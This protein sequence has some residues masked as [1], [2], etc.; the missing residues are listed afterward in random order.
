MENVEREIVISKLNHLKYNPHLL[1]DNNRSSIINM[2]GREQ[3]M[4]QA[5]VPPASTSTLTETKKSESKHRLSASS[6]A[7]DKSRK[8]TKKDDRPQFGAAMTVQ[9]RRHMVMLWKLGKLKDIPVF[10]QQQLSRQ[11]EISKSKSQAHKRKEEEEHT[12]NL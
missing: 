3:S 5:S 6:L 11:A 8:S 12:D 10:V 9:E 2:L 4:K 7:T 1:T